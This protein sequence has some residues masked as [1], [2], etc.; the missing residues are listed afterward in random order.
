VRFQKVSNAVSHNFVIVSK[1]DRDHGAIQE[2]E[3]AIVRNDRRV[4][5]PGTRACPAS[6]VLTGLFSMYNE[7]EIRQALLAGFP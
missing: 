6:P 1:E 7:Y 2:G 5:A 4:G 3:K